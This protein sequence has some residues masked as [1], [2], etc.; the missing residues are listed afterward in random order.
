MQQ[1]LFHF[2]SR[3]QIKVTRGFSIKT[4]VFIVNWKFSCIFLLFF[5]F[6]SSV[7]SVYCCIKAKW[8]R[9]NNIFVPY[10]KSQNSS[11]WGL[12]PI[13]KPWKS[14]FYTYWINMINVNFLL[15]SF[16]ILSMYF[17]LFA[18]D[19]KVKWTRRN[20]IFVP[21][22]KSQ[23]SSIWGLFPPSSRLNRYRG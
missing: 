6:S 16:L 10:K 12:F 13:N 2:P 21:S 4:C 11:I 14:F 23:K 22:K 18:V 5:L 17:F 20:N 1:I 7:I 15:L 3:T 19:Q 8:T 9:R